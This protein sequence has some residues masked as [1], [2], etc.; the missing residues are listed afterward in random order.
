MNLEPYCIRDE[1]IQLTNI[2]KEL[3]CEQKLRQDYM[4]NCV[5]KGDFT[6]A[7]FEQF[8]TTTR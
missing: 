3:A 2:N 1:K 8:N 6:E 5:Y 7:F 4:N